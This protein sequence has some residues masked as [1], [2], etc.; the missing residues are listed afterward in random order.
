[1]DRS[2]QMDE[3]DS[4][5]SIYYNEEFQ[6]T[7]NSDQNDKI[8]AIFWAFNKLPD[9]YSIK[10]LDVLGSHDPCYM[11]VK[12]LPPIEL[13]LTFPEDYP[14]KNP[15]E[16]VISCQWL[17]KSKISLLCKKLD[18]IW[19]EYGAVEI[20]YI[21]SDFLKNDALD[22]LGFANE[23]DLRELCCKHLSFM[24]KLKEN[25]EDN[26]MRKQE[27]YSQEAS[28]LKEIISNGTCSDI[29]NVGEIDTKNLPGTS[30]NQRVKN[31]KVYKDCHNKYR[32]EFPYCRQ[33]YVNKNSARRKSYNKNK[34]DQRAVLDLNLK[35]SPLRL[36]ENYNAEREVVQFLKNFYTCNICFS[37]KLGKDCTKFH[38][39]NH[40][41]CINCIRSYFTIKIKEGTVQSIKCPEDQCTSE[42]LPSHIKEI[43]SE[44]LFAKYDTVLLNTA[45]D[46]LSDIIYCPRQLCQYPVSW[47]P[48]EKMASCPNCQYV[49]CVTCKMV[50]H[51]VEPCQFKSSDVRKLIDEYENAT[52]DVKSKLES[53]YG[54]K[55]LENLVNNS[56]AEAWIKENSKTCP[57]CD[58]AIEKAQG[59][60]KMVC[61]KCNAFFCW[62]CGALLDANNPY[63]HYRD[64][65]SKC[66]NKLFY[67]M[68]D[69]E[70]EDED[71]DDWDLVN[72]G[73]E[74][75]NDGLE[76]DENDFIYIPH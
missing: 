46:T 3:I 35:T 16:F 26:I 4:L 8:Q 38:G 76:Y 56:K 22:F 52:A 74:F 58:V 72:N 7:G 33:K 14:S 67:L 29:V 62:L 51:G 69:A 65:N 1:M 23:L 2:A 24:Q 6:V 30:V 44:E 13:R 53:R 25:K 59:C 9:D 11:K 5:K 27:T 45:L 43:V 32:K 49:F 68:Y 39:C 12:Y 63:F 21:W 34:F 31:I 66:K 20:V 50:Y 42:A 17:P 19:T 61:W 36:L 15:P 55:S 40:V 60:N 28:A 75:P 10:Y 71:E 54:K 47:E 70:D 64:P 73:D 57:K 41:F 37:D 48:H 18:D